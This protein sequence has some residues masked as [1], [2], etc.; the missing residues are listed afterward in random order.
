MAKETTDK[1]FKND[2]IESETPVLVD[3]WASWCGPCK[4]LS[5]IIDELSKEFEGKVK[6]VKM[7]IDENPETPTELGVR[8]IPNLILFKDGKSIDSKVGAIPKA[9]LS[10]WLSG[11]LDK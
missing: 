6:I 4:Q 3:F 5:P 9:A 1:D 11:H 2:V 10:S 7:N 8:G